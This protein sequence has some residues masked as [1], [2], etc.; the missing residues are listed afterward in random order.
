MTG[1][2]LIR[3]F[4][5]LTGIKIPDVLAR[6][7]YAYNRQREELLAGDYIYS[8]YAA[9]LSDFKFGKVSAAYAGCAAV[10]IYN[11]LRFLGMPVSFSEVVYRL[12]QSGFLSMEGKMG[13]DP[14][15]LIG[16]LEKMTPLGAKGE[17]RCFRDPVQLENWKKETDKE[18]DNETN[19]EID[20]ETDNETN[21][22]ID[23]ET[24]NETNRKTDRKTDRKID[25]K[26]EEKTGKAEMQGNKKTAAI[27]AV[28]NDRNNPGKGMHF[29][30]LCSEGNGWKAMNRQDG[31]K[32]DRMYSFAED[33]L[34]N[35]RL[36]LGYCFTVV[37]C[38]CEFAG[39]KRYVEC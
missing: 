4:Y 34:G 5:K 32:S 17:W 35:S 13:T 36:I 19:N 33:S 6:E 11:A 27:L 39:E 10:A 8:Q 2:Y 28:W 31:S 14:C 21:N 18:T 37:N 30:M 16:A 12:E 22:E 25:W 7:H 15:R 23:N 3:F 29:Y 1:E 38:G 9:S 24:D 20:N 26:I